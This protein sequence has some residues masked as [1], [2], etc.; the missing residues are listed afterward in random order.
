MDSGEA[1]PG[2]AHWFRLFVSDFLAQ[3]GWMDAGV[4]GVYITLIAVMH[5]AGEPII[6]N[7]RHLARRCGATRKAF[8]NALAALIDVG[9]VVRQGD[10]LSSPLVDRE[11]AFYAKKSKSAQQSARDGWKK[12]KQNQSRD[13]ANAYKSQIS[14]SKIDSDAPKE[15]RKS[16]TSPSSKEAKTTVENEAAR[17]GAANPI[18]GREIR[19]PKI[20]RCY[21]DKILRKSP[22]TIAVTAS[23]ED[24]SYRV[25]YLPNDGFEITEI[26][27]GDVS[28]D[29]IEGED[30]D[31]AA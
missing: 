3:V 25:K 8:E 16:N 21:V 31:D 22:L 23:D 4:R 5:D 29:S 1:G 13:D 2:K 26:P 19:I 14:E 10:R 15:H 27:F 6:N 20:G 12:R 9:L 30:H 7:G 18:A 28:A 24:R 11:I 17:D